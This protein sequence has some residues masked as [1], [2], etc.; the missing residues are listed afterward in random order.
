[1][2]TFNF[3]MHRIGQ[4]IAH[5]R[6]EHNMTQMALADEMGVSFQAV[7]NWER[8]QSM[9]DI[10]KLPELAELFGT[11][12]DA[13][14]GRHS[15]LIEKAAENKLAELTDLNVEELTE[16]APL[17]PPKQMDD[18]ADKLLALEHLPDMGDLLRFLPTAKVDA[19][20]HQRM[21]A[22]KPLKE[23]AL[24]ASTNAVD[25]VARAHEQQGLPIGEIAPFMS[26]NCVDEIARCRTAAGRSIDELLP[27]LYEG[28]VNELA[29]QRDA[30]GHS[31]DD[32]MPFMSENALAEIALSR[33]QRGQKITSLLPF[34]GEA[35]I[36]RLAEAISSKD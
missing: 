28:S 14:L 25:A 11:T 2:A 16:A 29:R 21:E 6:R 13:L 34:V 20:L 31:I 27:F 10:S 9:P 26:E 15:P 17:L 18:L 22:G 19:L 24:F 7:S 12:I 4:T 8:G 5:L 33:L 36:T 3:D 1:M 30:S 35:L 23:Y 32:L